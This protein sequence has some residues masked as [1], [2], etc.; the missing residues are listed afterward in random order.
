MLIKAPGKRR[1]RIVDSAATTEDI[2]PTI[3]SYLGAR[4]SSG[5]RSLENESGSTKVTVA[6]EDGPVTVSL[7][8]FIRLRNQAADRIVELNR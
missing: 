3:G 7:G 8:E 2:L 6:G 4:W 1:G 5:G